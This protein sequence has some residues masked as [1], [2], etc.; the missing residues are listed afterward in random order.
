MKGQKKKG[1]ADKV[2]N[3]GKWTFTLRSVL[4]AVPVAVAA[5][6]LAVRNSFLLPALVSFDI[7]TIDAKALVFRTVTIDRSMAVVMPLVITLVCLILMFCSKKVVYPWL[8]SLFS[9]LLPLVLLIVN[10][11]P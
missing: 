5:V 10:T 9:L 4:F 6:F 8:V 2:Y 7:A 3:I 1:F 11:F